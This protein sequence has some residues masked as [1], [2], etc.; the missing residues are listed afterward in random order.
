MHYSRLS[1]EEH[2]L[3][4]LR[5]ARKVDPDHREGHHVADM[6]DIQR[7]H[8]ELLYKNCVAGCR[9]GAQLPAQKT[10]FSGSSIQPS[11]AMSREVQFPEVQ[12]ITEVDI[13]ESVNRGENMETS[14]CHVPFMDTSDCHVSFSFLTRLC[15]SSRSLLDSHTERGRYSEVRDNDSAGVR[16]LPGVRRARSPVRDDSEPAVPFITA[17]LLS[18]SSPSMP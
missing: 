14:D 18:M 10:S 15:S 9:L 3:Q 17:R 8:S 11:P 2:P 13:K 4:M 1:A 5:T 12:F 6:L 7:H 16:A